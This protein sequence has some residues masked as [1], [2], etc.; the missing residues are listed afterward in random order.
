MKVAALVVD[1]ITGLPAVLLQPVSSAEEVEPL[2]IPVGKSEASAIATKL[3]RI[4][5]E[6]PCTHMLMGML[7]ADSGARIERVEIHDFAEGSYRARIHLVLPGGARIPHEVRPSDGLALALYT[8]AVIE[9][10]SAIV[11]PTRPTSRMRSRSPGR[12][13]NRGARMRG[14]RAMAARRRRSTKE[15]AD[16]VDPGDEVFGKWKM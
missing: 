1:P 8:G 4:E 7:V 12:G 16:L 13:G 2:A 14:T 15:T 9:V 6:R 10:A 5:L 3:D 11:Q